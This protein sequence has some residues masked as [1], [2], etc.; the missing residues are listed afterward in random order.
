[1]T[2]AVLTFDV[3]AFRVQFKAF[4]NPS[5]YPN[6]ML[7][8][9]WDMATSYVSSTN[10][11]WL[12]GLSRELAI[13]LMTAHLLVLNDQII[14]GNTPV[15]TNSATVDKVSVSLTPPPAK[16]GW[17]WWLSLSPYGQQLWALLLQKGNGGL[18]VGGFPETNSFRRNYGVYI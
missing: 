4:Q 17:E 15:L 1:M 5:I 7:Q 10:Y 14:S 12:N 13:N 2:V 11:G 16:T 6:S 3:A 9:Y 18:Y 8:M